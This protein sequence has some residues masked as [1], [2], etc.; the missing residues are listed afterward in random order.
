MLGHTDIKTTQIY[1]NLSAKLM[2]LLIENKML[3]TERLRKKYGR[4]YYYVT[5]IAGNLLLLSEFII[6]NI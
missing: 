4:D 1:D 5:L 3:N 2:S 6:Q